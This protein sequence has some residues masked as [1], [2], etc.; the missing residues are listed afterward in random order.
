VRKR[1]T[2]EAKAKIA[3]DAIKGQMTWSQI[4]S[5]HKVNQQRINV[6]KR[7]AEDGILRTFSDKPNKSLASAE[8]KNEELLKMLG[9]AQLEN[10]WLKKKSKLFTD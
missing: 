9:E 8:A 2:P 10:A 7:A 3:I 5:K 1:L 4:C 6:L